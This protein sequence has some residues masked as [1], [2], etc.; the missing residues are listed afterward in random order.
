MGASSKPLNA[1]AL[2]KADHRAVEELF[3][4]Y[5]NAHGHEQKAKIAR[6]ICLELL[7][8]STIEEEIFYPAV[9]GEIEDDTLDR[10]YVEHD[11]AKLLIA[12]LL[13]GDPGDEFYDAKVKVLSEEILHHVHEEEKRNDGMFTQARDA[14]VDLE[15]LGRRLAKRKEEL[16]EQFAQSGLPP[17]ETRTLRGAELRHGHAIA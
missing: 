2:L 3:E 13:E 9:R 14:G 7:M 5:Q 11:G 6:Q 17:P 4:K 8:H 1:V 10:A 15:E 12:E 16:R